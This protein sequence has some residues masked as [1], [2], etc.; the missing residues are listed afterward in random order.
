M[1][2]SPI[3]K[4]IEIFSKLPGIG[5]RQGTRLAFHFI[6][7]GK[8]KIDEA[9]RAINNLK[10]LKLCSQCFAPHLNEGCLCD[11]CKD[12]RRDKKFIAIIEKETD[13]L[14]LEKTKKFR[15]IYLILGELV[16]TGVLENIQKL[17]LNHLKS[18][19]E[20][21]LGGQAEEII[22]AI[23]PTAYGDLN[24]LILTQELKPFAKKIT[25]L[26]QGL[27][28]GGEI[29]FADEETLTSAFERRS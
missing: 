1:L 8:D 11:I 23:N 7:A 22:L 4:F 27:P 26:G 3:E 6:N 15:G 24:A 2:P 21:E 28:R 5:P 20:K 19:I 29:E 18:F 16:K 17:R 9:A 10:S 14:S 13:Q 25:R 12:P